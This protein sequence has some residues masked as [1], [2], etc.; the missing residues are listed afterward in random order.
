M[1]LRDKIAA[2][3]AALR[4]GV[5]PVAA[6][7]LFPTPADVA[8]RVAAYAELAPGLSVLEPSAGTGALVRAVH[9][10]EP[11]ADVQPIERDARLADR[12]GCPCADFLEIRPRPIYDRVV[13]NPPFSGGADIRH[14]ERALEFLRPGGLLVAIVADGPRQAARLAAQTDA[15]RAV[16]DLERL[17]AGTFAGTQVRARIVRIRT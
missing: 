15:G 1:N 12:M 8:A 13:M 6:H 17:P 5:V 11:G 16:E 4:G 10:A 7:D 14:V 2:G 9:E 3:R